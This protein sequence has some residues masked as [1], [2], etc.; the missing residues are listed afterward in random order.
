MVSQRRKAAENNKFKEKAIK[1][2]LNLANPSAEERE[3]ES[4]SNKI[5]IANTIITPE[6]R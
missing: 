2:F 1:I 6:I 3:V 5:P 4:V